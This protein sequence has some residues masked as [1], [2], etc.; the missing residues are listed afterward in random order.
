MPTGIYL[1]YFLRS[2]SNSREEFINYM[3]MLWQR[4]QARKAAREDMAEMR[5]EEKEKKN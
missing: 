3:H 5:K 2:V 1:I 4:A